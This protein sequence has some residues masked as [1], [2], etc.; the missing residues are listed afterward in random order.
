M[1]T[2]VR[3][4][5]YLCRRRRRRRQ[6]GVFL[7]VCALLTVRS[8]LVSRQKEDVG[9]LGRR[10]SKRD[11]SPQVLKSWAGNRVDRSPPCR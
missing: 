10:E 6:P 4:V 7:E 5:V 3:A 11:S 2:Y 8:P 1:G 9:E